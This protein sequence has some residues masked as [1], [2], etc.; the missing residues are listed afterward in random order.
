[1]IDIHSHILPGIDDGAD[2]IE[3]TIEMLKVVQADRVKTIFATPHYYRGHFENDYNIVKR[4]VSDIRNWISLSNS[5]IKIEVLPG[6]EVFINNYTLRLYK[7]GIIGT[8]N[9]TRYMLVE[10]PFDN[11]DN[12]TLD[13]IYELRLLGVVP[14]I[15]HPERYSYIIEKP[16]NI[17]Q[18]I[19]EGCLFQINSGNIQGGINKQAKKTADTLIK[20]GIC[21]FIASDVHRIGNRYTRVISAY[22]KVK[23]SNS[24]LGERILENMQK[25]IENMPIEHF[26]EKIKERHSIFDITTK[27]L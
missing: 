1:M 11:L 9:N 20:H 3:T 25:L 2:N 23:K 15:A 6:Q 4:Y 13:V 14:I 18:L 22:E 7:E 21:D 19:S 26:S 10:L 27:K 16:S 24:K 8:L 12:T 5:D 17:N